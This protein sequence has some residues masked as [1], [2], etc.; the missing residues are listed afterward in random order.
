MFIIIYRTRLSGFPPELPAIAGVVLKIHKVGQK[1]GPKM[2][3]IFATDARTVPFNAA[4]RHML[5]LC[6]VKFIIVK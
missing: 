3:Q 5:H 4:L 2:E 6:A 1:L